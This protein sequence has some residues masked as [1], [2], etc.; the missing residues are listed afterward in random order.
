MTPTKARSG[1]AERPDLFSMC[2][3]VIEM[4][5]ISKPEVYHERQSAAYDRRLCC[6]LAI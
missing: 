1:D 6:R 5:L 3:G 4:L 2:Q